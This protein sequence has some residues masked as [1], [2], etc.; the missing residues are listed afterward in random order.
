MPSSPTLQQ[1]L[2]KFIQTRTYT[3]SKPAAL[4]EIPQ[5]SHALDGREMKKLKTTHQRQ[6]QRALSEDELAM[7]RTPFD[8]TS[9]V[10]QVARDRES[11][12]AV[13]PLYE[14]HAEETDTLCRDP[15][16]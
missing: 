9:V 3:K 5:D 10:Q 2:R 13:R 7:P 14:C 1:P 15:K 6:G 12:R 4:L 16:S 11:R 8:E